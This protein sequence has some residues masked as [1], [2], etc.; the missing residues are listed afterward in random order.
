[1]TTPFTRRLFCLF[2]LALLATGSVYAQFGVGWQRTPT[3]TVIGADEKDPRRAM[4]DEAI[5]FWNKTLHEVDSGFRLGPA[6]QLTRAVPEDALR[7]LSASI[8]G[9]RGPVW[10]PSSLRNLPADMTIMLGDSDFVSFAG[11]FDADGKRVVAIRGM[12]LPPLNL[13]N[14][15]PNVVTHELGHALGIGHNSDPTMLMCGRPAPC[16]PNLFQ[17]NEPKLFPL[18]HDEKQLLRTLYPADWKPRAP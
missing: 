16:R 17:S 10:V 2:S 12:N 9:G 15:A 8:V 4:V 5:D 7:S 14:V 1:M 3:I 18:T 6:T 13:P 11:P